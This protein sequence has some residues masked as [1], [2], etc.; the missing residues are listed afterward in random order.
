MILACGPSQASSATLQG[1]T[2]QV[3]R[4]LN[5]CRRQKAT[6]SLWVEFTITA[7]AWCTI[8]TD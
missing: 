8:V 1:S 3:R 2:A 5:L 6:G 4:E 7:Y